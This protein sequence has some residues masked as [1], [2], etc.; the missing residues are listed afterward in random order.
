MFSIPRVNVIESDRGF[1]IELLGRTGMHYKEKD[2]TIF[3]ECEI[4][5]TQSPNIALWKD[6]TMEWHF[7]YKEEAITKEM[8]AKIIKN[9]CDALE[10]RGVDVKIL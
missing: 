2:K 9:I 3:I 6:C 7:P 8:R 10:W 5:M 4:L 1:S